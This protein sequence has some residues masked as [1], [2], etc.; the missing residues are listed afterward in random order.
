MNRLDLKYKTLLK[1][2]EIST[3]L[4]VAH[5][6]AQIDHESGLKPISENLNYS[7]EGLL[8]TFSKYF[9]SSQAKIYARQPEKIANRVYGNRMG[10]GDEVSGDGWKYRGRGFLQITGKNNYVKLREDTGVDYVNNPDLLLTE[11]D[12][13][14]SACWYWKTNN[15]NRFADKD[16]LDGVSD[17]I[18][19]G[20]KTDRYGD[21]NG[22]KDRKEKLIKWKKLW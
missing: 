14:I 1:K 8:K 3:P 21:A 12:S 18:N 10:N 7:A 9:T 5:F 11:A 15:I 13:M 16:D 4:R 2:W 22:F 20:K 6:M 19:L 17:L